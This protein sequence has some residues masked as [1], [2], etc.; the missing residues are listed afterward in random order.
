MT[1][2]RKKLLLIDGSSVLVR[3]YFA[4]AYSGRIRLAKTGAPTNAVMGFLNMAFAAVSL[5]EPTHLFVAWDVSRDTFRRALFPE[6][7]GTRGE[8]PDEM[9][10]QFDTMQSVLRAF[11]IQQYQHAEYEADDILGTLATL[12]QT[13]G[14]DATIL[15]GDRD[16]LQ[17]VDQQITVAIMKKGVKEMDKYTPETLYAQYGLQPAQMIDLKGLMGDTSDNIPGV[18]GIGPKTATQL[19]KDHGT[20]ERVLD[21][22]SQ[23]RGKTAERLTEH[24]AIALLSK[25]LATIIRDMPLPFSPHECALNVNTEA[26]LEKLEELDLTHF[27]RHVQTLQR[28]G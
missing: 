6:Y 20:L 3:A 17:L 8:L 4:S 9:L 16:A 1:I 18:P 13:E 14:Y 24:R 25:Q 19:L 15:T 2:E 27:N 28:I 10:C 12:A 11:G 21:G 7:K 26:A 5:F 22:A 23:L